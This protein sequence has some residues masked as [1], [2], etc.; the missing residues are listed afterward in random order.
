MCDRVYDWKTPC[1]VVSSKIRPS[2][3]SL[4]HRCPRPRRLGLRVSRTSSTILLRR[5]KKQPADGLDNMRSVQRRGLCCGRVSTLRAYTLHVEEELLVDLQDRLTRR[6]PPGV[7][8]D[9]D[10][11]W[12]YGTDYPTCRKGLAT[13]WRQGRHLASARMAREHP[14]ISGIDRND[15]TTLGPRWV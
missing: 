6:R 4:C 7:P 5:Q 9:H 13:K 1:G 15:E 8:M 14:R 10:H 2:V 3:E 11:G 12:D